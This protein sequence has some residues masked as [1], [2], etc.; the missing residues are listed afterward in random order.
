MTKPLLCIFHSNCADGFTAAWAVYKKH[1]DTEFHPGTYG[2][3]PPNCSGRDVVMVDFSYKREVLLQIAA[4]ANTVLILDHHKSAAGDLIDLPLNVTAIFDMNRSGAMMAWNHYHP[5]VEPSKLI[6]H[7]E[8]RDLWLFNIDHTR[9]FQAN[10]FSFEYSFEKWDAVSEICE[11]PEAYKNFIAQGEAI[12]RK[13]FKNVKELIR[14]AAHRSVIAGHDVPTLNAPYFY[15]SDA[16]HQMSH[17]EAFSA[18]YYDTADSRVYSLRSQPDGF[19]VSMIAAQFGGGG[20]K[21]AAGFRVSLNELSRVG[22]PQHKAG[23]T[24]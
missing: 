23:V 22:A 17:G 4:V 19:D 3:E 7:V 8:D 10:L 11:T 14:T 20:H 9:A 16:G 15:S 12:E 5:G 13:H 24:D 2:E 1:P 18:C 21:N 6:R